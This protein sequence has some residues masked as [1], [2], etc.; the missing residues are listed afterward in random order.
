MNVINFLNRIAR[1]F[2]RPELAEEA[3]RLADELS[4]PHVALPSKEE[5]T[6][7]FAQGLSHTYHCTRVWSAWGVG[8]MSRD[9]FLPVDESETP[10]ELADAVLGM[11]VGQQSK[12][13][14]A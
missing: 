12:G 2:T 1:D 4:G 13:G 10:G 3:R 14:A 11:L 8:T 9:D 5:L 7:L 6:D